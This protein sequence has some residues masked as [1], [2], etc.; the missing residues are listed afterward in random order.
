MFI[1]LQSMGSY[2]ALCPCRCE[3]SILDGIEIADA[4]L[5]RPVVLATF[6]TPAGLVPAVWIRCPAMLRKASL[7]PQLYEPR[8]PT[9]LPKVASN[10]SRP[11]SI[12]EPLLCIISKSFAFSDFSLCSFGLQSAWAPIRNDL[13]RLPVIVDDILTL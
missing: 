9:I 8:R 10:Q 13:R 6:A 7:D 2:W 1:D 4:G 12:S 3:V 11:S 5:L